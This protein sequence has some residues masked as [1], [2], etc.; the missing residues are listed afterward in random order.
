MAAFGGPDGLH[1]GSYL[2]IP[3]SK[4]EYEEYVAQFPQ[5]AHCRVK[6]EDRVFWWR[7]GMIVERIVGQKKVI[8]EG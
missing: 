8:G 3:L 1:W 5:T 6:S 4:E 7:L 2:I